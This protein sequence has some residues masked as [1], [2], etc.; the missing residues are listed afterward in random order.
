MCVFI[1]EKVHCIL[2]EDE[3][4][5]IGQN[6][7]LVICNC[8]ANNTITPEQPCD[9][10]S[11]KCRCLPNWEGERCNDD[12]DECQQELH[13]CDVTKEICR[14]L[15]G[16]FECD[17]IQAVVLKQTNGTCMLITI[18]TIATFT[19]R[20]MSIRHLPFYKH[21]QTCNLELVHA[22]LLL[23]TSILASPYN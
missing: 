22:S 16:G 3:R 5:T 23:V 18:M 4:S 10:D 11:G 13:N 2:T 20:D 15:P 21:A 12:V 6:N 19:T 7:T 1:L 9:P 8:T 17:V 14:N